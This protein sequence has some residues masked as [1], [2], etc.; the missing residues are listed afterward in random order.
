MQVHTL[1]S[2]FQRWLT[3]AGL[4]GLVLALM[5][6]PS[7]IWAQ[8]AEQIDPPGRVAYISLKEGTSLM[9]TDG[10]GSWMPATLNMP[11]T[12]GVSLATEVN[13]RTELHSGWSA[14][15]LAGKSNLEITELDDTTTRLALTEGTLSARVRE[16]QPGER[17]EVDTPN[18]ALVAEQ[19]GE[20]RFD[21]NAGNGTTRITV[22]SGRA[23]VYGEAGQAISVGPRE[24]WLFS[25]RA[26]TQ[27]SRTTVTYRD[28]FDQWVAS[29][30]GLEER[31]NSIRYVSQGIPGYQQLDAYGDWAEDPT[32]GAVWYPR[33]SVNDW[34]P[35]RYGQWSWVDPWG[36]T[37]VDDAPWG[38]APFH[39]G[40]WAQIGPRWAWVPG[41]KVRRPVYAPALVGFVAGSSGNVNWGISIGQNTPGAAWFPLAPG[42][43]WE[44]HYRTSQRY[45]QA[46]NPWSNARPPKPNADFRFQRRPNAITVGSRDQFGALEGRQPRFTNGTRFSSDEWS[47]AR[48][49]PPPPRTNDPGRSI[50]RHPRNAGT[51]DWQPPSRSQAPLPD[52]PWQPSREARETQH[53]LER[54]NEWQRQQAQQRERERQDREREREIQQQRQLDTNR[55]VQQQRELQQQ[56]MFNRQREMR[57]QQRQIDQRRAEQQE[58]QFRQRRELQQQMNQPRQMEPPAQRDREHPRQWQDRSIQREGG[59]PGRQREERGGGPRSGGPSSRS[60]N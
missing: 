16:L 24:Q 7:W 21:V 56:Q 26:L 13:S 28:S 47:G 38:F 23:V 40:R 32:Y 22:H 30:D 11:I 9:A 6:V 31:S 25:G 53:Q 59:P 50:E 51:R 20:Y 27:V 15:R 29:R 5:T 42:E 58:Q 35:Y 41:P 57:E 46:L 18:I 49:I 10:R 19:P 14:I 60:E 2:R 4:G 34:A 1:R 33:L 54:M 55:A 37:W 44:P 45:R 17:F 52:K 3:T 48:I 12:S 8:Q 36:W 43:Y 39:Y